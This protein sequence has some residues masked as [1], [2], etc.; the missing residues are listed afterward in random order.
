[1]F[2]RLLILSAL[3]L[4]FACPEPLH[5]QNKLRKGTLSKQKKSEPE[6][7]EELDADTEQTGAEEIPPPAASSKN[8]GEKPMPYIYQGAFKNEV[9][10]SGT[11]GLYSNGQETKSNKDKVSRLSVEADYRRQLFKGIQ[12][13]TLV[14]VQNVSSGSSYS[15]MD[16]YGTFTYNFAES[17]NL[18]NTS[19]ALGLIGMA[20]ESCGLKS[21]DKKL[22]FGAGVGKRYNLANQ[23]AYVPEVGLKKVGENDPLIYLKFINFSFSF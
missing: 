21:S 20:E 17:W 18:N 13:G 19:Y 7:D 14:N 6:L 3:V 8:R 2:L 4:S 15:C 1:M 5:A 16:V 9:V 22:S 11:S 10:A 23:V 12:L